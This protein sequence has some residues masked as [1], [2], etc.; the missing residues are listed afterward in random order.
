MAKTEGA[1]DGAKQRLG[2]LQEPEPVR[3][4]DPWPQIPTAWEPPDLEGYVEKLLAKL[5]KVD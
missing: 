5:D 4:P 3:A 1:T 2:E